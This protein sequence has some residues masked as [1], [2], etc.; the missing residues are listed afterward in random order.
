MEA[1]FFCLSVLKTCPIPLS[2]PLA[3][4]AI[5]FMCPQKLVPNFPNQTYVSEYYRSG[6]LTLFKIHVLQKV[7]KYVA[8]KTSWL[9]S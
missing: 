5:T 7:V 8:I 3:K 4:L 1:I 9:F 6:V 2:I